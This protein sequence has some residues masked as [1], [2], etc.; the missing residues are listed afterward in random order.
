MKVLEVE[1]QFEDRFK[2]I[3]DAMIDT[4]KDIDE[5]DRFFDQETKQHAAK[6][7]QEKSLRQQIGTM[8]VS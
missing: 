3:S 4:E 8:E 2:G 1:K 5:C 6:V 7:E